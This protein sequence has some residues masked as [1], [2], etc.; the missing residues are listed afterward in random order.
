[1]LPGLERHFDVLAV[2]L[3]GF[4][5]SP[6]FPAGVTPTIEGFADAVEEAME[7]AGFERPLVVGNSLGG[8]I[9]MELARR[10][11]VRGAV[12][13]SPAGLMAPREATWARMVLNSMREMVKGAPAVAPLLRTAVGRTLL[14]GP[15]L[16]RPWRA[17]PDDLIEQAALLQH[18]PG[19]IPTLGELRPNEHVAGLEEIRCPVLVLWGTRDIILLPR[20]GRRFERLI[21]GAELKYLKG[22]G[23]VPMSDDPDLLV[24]EITRF[25]ER[26]AT[27][28]L[29]IAA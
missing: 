10:G 23:H 18:A 29:K 16:G 17:D 27:P 22:L 15:S 5:H 28:T 25:A 8:W 4:G 19:W 26:I 3:P 12:G 21:D 9:S 13:L 1:M 2:D 7:G 11:S 20:Q 6:P 24:D 14:A